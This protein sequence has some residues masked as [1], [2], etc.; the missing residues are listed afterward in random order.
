MK[1]ILAGGS[2]IVLLMLLLRPHPAVT[3]RS[4]DPR[5]HIFNVR[6]FPTTNAFDYW[7]LPP[8][9]AVVYRAQR[10]S[11]RFGISHSSWVYRWLQRGAQQPITAGSLTGGPAL[12]LYRTRL[13]HEAEFVLMTDG[14]QRFQESHH[15]GD[16]PPF[17]T[18]ETVD[19]YHGH[20]TNGWYHLREY[21]RVTNIAD[22]R[23]VW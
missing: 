19:V 14:G 9:R 5:L 11:E 7:Y 6:Y 20:L 12:V 16:V 13:A 1:R 23:V 4:L 15:D 22:I 8:A 21:G 3:V 18:N 2:A 17:H 10:A